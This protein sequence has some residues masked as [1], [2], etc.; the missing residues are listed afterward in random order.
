MWLGTMRGRLASWFRKHFIRDVLFSRFLAR[1][2]APHFAMLTI[3]YRNLNHVPRELLACAPGFAAGA[4]GVGL[5]PLWAHGAEHD[6]LLADAIGKLNR[7]TAQ[8]MSAY[9][10]SV[11]RW[12]Q[13]LELEWLL[14][15]P[16]H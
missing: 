12:L 3:P 13:E 8:D 4:V 11:D 6:Q 7:I 14:A 5:A 1:H 2:L 15:Q 10:L 9:R 16:L